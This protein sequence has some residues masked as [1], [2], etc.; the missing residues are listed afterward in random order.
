MAE[1][2]GAAL[3]VTGHRLSPETRDSLKEASRRTGVDF[4]FLLAQATVESGLRGGV[5]ARQRHS[6]AAGLFQFTAQTWLQMMRDHGAEFGEGE[7]AGRITTLADGRLGVPDRATEGKIL[8]LR[9][10]VKLAAMMAGEFAKQNRQALQRALHRPASPAELHLAHLLGATGA[11]RLLRARAADATQPAAEVV[12]A[13]AKQ[14]PQLFFARGD[15]TP[16]TVAAVY[17]KIKAR[18]ETPLKQIAAAGRQASVA[19]GL[20]PGRGLTDALP[21]KRGV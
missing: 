9:K 2:Q 18:I 17:G 1:E 7:L 5:Q 21:K 20:R 10:D 19:D 12:P 13:A 8:D 4:D 3:T 11:I 16:H 15:H 14:N 6:S